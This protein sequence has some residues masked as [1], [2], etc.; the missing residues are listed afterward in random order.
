MRLPIQRIKN[1]ILSLIRR[2]ED[3]QRDALPASSSV[4]GCGAIALDHYLCLRVILPQESLI[5]QKTRRHN[6]KSQSNER[7]VVDGVLEI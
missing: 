2:F 3:D 1:A 7:W 5:R 4:F 6:G